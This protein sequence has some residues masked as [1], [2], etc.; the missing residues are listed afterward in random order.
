MIGLQI[1]VFLFT[2]ISCAAAKATHLIVANQAGSSIDV[3]WV[4]QEKNTYVP[5]STIADLG[6]FAVSYIPY[7]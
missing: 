1:L 7:N 4:N 3:F 5:M 2:L 6:R